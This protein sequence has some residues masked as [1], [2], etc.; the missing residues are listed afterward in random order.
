MA[1]SVNEPGEDCVSVEEGVAW[2]ELFDVADELPVVL[3]ESPDLGLA[4]VGFCFLGLLEEAVG[5]S[6]FEVEVVFCFEGIISS[7]F[8]LTRR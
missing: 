3:D 6:T 7:I 5:S 2:A 8:L 4:N 1:T